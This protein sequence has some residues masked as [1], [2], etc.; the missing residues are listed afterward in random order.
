[1]PIR[2]KRICNISYR[3]CLTAQ[4]TPASSCP[5]SCIKIAGRIPLWGT[6]VCGSTSGELCIQGLVSGEA[7]PHSSSPGHAFPISV[8]CLDLMG[9][10]CVV[11]SK[12]SGKLLPQMHGPFGWAKGL[13]STTWIPV[14]SIWRFKDIRVQNCRWC[15]LWGVWQTESRQNSAEGILLGCCKEVRKIRRMSKGEKKCKV[16]KEATN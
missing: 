1:M 14:H 9:V 5:G 12:A 15:R 16:Q 8:G 13:E 3:K 6:V 11:Q 10:L 2:C 4:P 7:D